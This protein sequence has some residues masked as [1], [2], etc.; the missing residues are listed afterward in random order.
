M[1]TTTKHLMLFIIAI[2]CTNVVQVA[3][4]DE[5]DII[6]TATNKIE[7]LKDE[8]FKQFETVDH[9]NK[10]YFLTKNSKCVDYDIDVA[11]LDLDFEL[12]K[13]DRIKTKLEKLGYDTETLPII[14]V[15]DDSVNSAKTEQMIKNIGITLGFDQHI[16][17]VQELYASV[18]T[19]HKIANT[20]KNIKAGK[21]ALLQLDTLF[22]NVS[23]VC[24]KNKLEEIYSIIKSK[25][26]KKNRVY[27]PGQT[28]L[29]GFDGPSL[30][31]EKGC[32]W[33][34][35]GNKMYPGKKFKWTVKR[36]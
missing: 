19:M 22:K 14:V 26:A 33:V 10:K 27:Q 7:N 34:R 13:L 17:S 32:E 24:T 20:Q 23:D 11:K 9:F 3:A 1:F 30:P 29:A 15:N 36:K 4:Y 21:L 12:K 25:Y 8:Y 31:V 28:V 6:F 5:Q 18:T 35:E 16:V 2:V